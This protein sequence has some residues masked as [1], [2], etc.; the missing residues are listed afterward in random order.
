MIKS[1]FYRPAASEVLTS[2]LKQAKEPPWTSFF[3]KYVSV[4]NDQFGKSHF[5]WKVGS[6]NYHVLRTGC[7]PYIKYHCS[8]RIYQNLELENTMMTAIKIINF[9]R[10]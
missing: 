7:F 8:K 5:N 4:K 6:S 1:R 2:Y 9:G 3:V 10:Y